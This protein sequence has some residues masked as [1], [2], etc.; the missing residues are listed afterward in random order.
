MLTRRSTIELPRLY[1]FGLLIRLEVIEHD[2]NSILHLRDCSVH[3]LQLNIHV[4][5]SGALKPQQ[6]EVELHNRSKDQY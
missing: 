3:V 6:G 4:R 2:T 1:Y 5:L